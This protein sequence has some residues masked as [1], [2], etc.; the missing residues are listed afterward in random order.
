MSSAQRGAYQQ[1]AS[2]EELNSSRW[3]RRRWHTGC[4]LCATGRGEHLGPPKLWKWQSILVPCQVAQR[5]RRKPLWIRLPTGL[6]QLLAL[7]AWISRDARSEDKRAGCLLDVRAKIQRLG[8]HLVK[9]W[10]LLGRA[11]CRIVIDDV[12]ELVF[13]SIV[14]P[15]QESIVMTRSGL[16]GLPRPDL[17]IPIDP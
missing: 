9:A 15:H 16:D 11:G 14:I 6:G 10:L 7:G 12:L 5:L 2:R 3:R 13:F 8:A 1:R 17:V 4:K